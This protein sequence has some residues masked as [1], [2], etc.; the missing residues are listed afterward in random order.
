MKK[1]NQFGSLIIQQCSDFKIPSS[2]NSWL[3]FSQKSLI[4]VSSQAF[5]KSLLRLHL[6]F[7]YS[8]ALLLCLL[9]SSWE[10]Q[11]VP[12]LHIAQL[13]QFLLYMPHTVLLLSKLCAKNHKQ[14]INRKNPLSIILKNVFYINSYHLKQLKNSFLFPK[15]LRINY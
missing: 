3:A 11:M 2:Q 14:A 6:L 8:S 12:N 4:S 15:I 9:Y 7:V 13:V 10:I 5:V 1:K